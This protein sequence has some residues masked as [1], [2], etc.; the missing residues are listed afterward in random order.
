MIAPGDEVRL[1]SSGA[2]YDVGSVLG[3][4]GQGV[5][6]EARPRLGGAAVALKWY[7]RDAATRKQANRLE[8][9]LDAGRPSDA[10]LW[11]LELAGRAQSVGFGYVMPR[12]LDPFEPLTRVMT[13]RTEMRLRP[14]CIAAARLA[15]AFLRL[16]ARGLC[17]ADI[18]LGNLFVD[19][20]TGDVLI[21]DNDNVTVDGQPSDVLG[22]PYFMAPEIVRGEASPGTA[23]DRYS[24]GVILFYL[25]LRHHPLFGARESA[26]P[27]LD[28]LSLTRLLGAEPVFVFDPEDDS[29]RP[30]PRLHDNAILR[31]PALPAFIR[32]M[33]VQ[34]FTA[35][36]KDPVHG[37]VTESQ[38]RAAAVRLRGLVRH[39]P[40]C[41]T[42]QF[43]DQ[44]S[45]AQP[46]A[47][48]DC[49][50]TMPPPVRLLAK[51][52]TVLEPGL[53][54]T[55]GDLGQAVD[56]VEQPVG[57]VVRHPATGAL[58]LRNRTKEPWTLHR[59]GGDGAVPPRAAVLLKPETELAI[60]GVHYRVAM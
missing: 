18:S 48:P 9:I 27:V 50:A 47:A 52:P 14:T 17:Y 58:A 60:A 21:C 10:F 31:W 39:C 32:T 46:C 12:R 24:L 20:Q 43:W 1:R 55:S 26:A 8:R 6:F 44:E 11:P 40:V 53:L 19:A 36:I 29:N 45:P 56:R 33:F 23:T 51:H 38:W 35:G 54:L 59:A 25:L 4:G 41:G 22:T 57:D 49:R 7:R 28:G 13:G 30:V 42:E 3:A 37:R 34:A 5:V 16:H 2:V 15:D